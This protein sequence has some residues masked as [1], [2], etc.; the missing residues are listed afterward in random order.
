[1]GGAVRCFRDLCAHRGTAL[2]LGWLEQDQLR[3][4]YHGWTYG[5][6][7]VC[8]SIPARFGAVIPTRARTKAFN[9][10]ESSGLIWVSL[11]DERVL[12]VPDFPQFGAA[13]FRCIEVPPYRWR[14]SAPRRIENYIDVSHLAW[15]HDGVLGDREHPQV[16]DHDVVR[17]DTSINFEYAGQVESMDIGKNQALADG[18]SQSFTSAL[19]YTLFVPGTVLIEQTLPGEHTYALFFSVCPAGPKDLLNFTFI[20]RDYMLDDV[21]AG[22]RSMLEYNDLVIGQDRPVVESQRPEQLPFDLSAELHIRGVDRASLEYRKWL[23]EL[24]NELVP[25]SAGPAGGAAAT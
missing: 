15:V 14:T 22:D 1:M 20:A 24:T 11:A 4:P 18:S 13:G 16:H 6:D 9:V 25:A 12:P 7:G 2:S 21:E 5:P 3:C 23:I 17:T 8:T 10:Q 19:R